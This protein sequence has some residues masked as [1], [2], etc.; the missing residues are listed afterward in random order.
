[1]EMI[2]KSAQHNLFLS[3]ESTELSFVRKVGFFLY[4][5][6][7]CM[8]V[9]IA[10]AWIRHEAYLEKQLMEKLAQDLTFRPRVHDSLCAGQRAMF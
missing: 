5:N 1:M 10:C 3:W 4:K 9:V 8:L 7:L 2:C 6:T